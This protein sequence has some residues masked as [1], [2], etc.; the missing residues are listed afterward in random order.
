MK[1]FLLLLVLLSTHLNAQKS[2]S[3]DKT[4]LQCEDKWI[5]YQMDKDS[6]YHYGFIYID[7]QAGLTLHY[8]GGFKIDE[9]GSFYKVDT[10]KK[11]DVAFVKI[12]LQPNKI[13]IAVLPEEK[14]SDLNIQK[15]PEWLAVYKADEGSVYRLYRWGFMYNGW[16]EIEKA[17]TFLEK[18]EKIDPNFKGLQTEL[19]FSYNAIGFYDKAEK[20]LKKAIANNPMDCY[21]YKELAY[22]YTKLEQIDKVIATYDVMV[23]YCKETNFIQETAYNLAFEYFKNKDKTQFNIWKI[24]TKKWSKTENQYIKNITQMEAELNKS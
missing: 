24:E 19:A 20:S 2:L 21:T 8:E 5:A 16:N 13:A 23:K 1:Y 3:F 6:I 9:K 12:R 18:A 15:F 11:K 17:L 14:F 10:D 4:N 7:A 22:T